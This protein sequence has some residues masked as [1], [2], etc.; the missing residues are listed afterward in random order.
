M[1]LQKFTIDFPTRSERL[2][3]MDFS[4]FALRARE[5]SFRDFAYETGKFNRRY[6][7]TGSDFSVCQ[8][9]W[10]IFIFPFCFSSFFLFCFGMCIS[11]ALTSRN[12]AARNVSAVLPHSFGFRRK[13]GK[14]EGFLPFSLSTRRE[15]PAP[16]DGAHGRGK[17]RYR[18]FSVHN[19]REMNSRRRFGPRTW[20]NKYLMRA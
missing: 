10:R 8:S 9:P 17:T 2:R 15:K 20:T 7:L 3:E 1:N 14:L 5:R 18:I 16:K 11:T 19:T 13:G 6:F 12:F 4:P